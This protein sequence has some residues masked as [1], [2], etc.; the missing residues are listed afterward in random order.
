MGKSKVVYYGTT[1]I[2]LTS[3]TVEPSKLISGYTAHDK[4][5][6]PIVGVAAGESTMVV[7]A[8]ELADNY[9]SA[10]GFKLSYDNVNTGQTFV[11]NSVNTTQGIF[12]ETANESGASAWFLEAVSGYTN[13]YYIY[14]YDSGVKK[15]M[16][17]TTGNQMGL[18]QTNKSAFDVSYVSDTKFY[19]KLVGA[20]KWLQHSNGGGGIR[21]YTD[22]NNPNNTQLSLTYVENAIVPHGTLTI[23]SNGTYDV[24]NYAEVVVNV[25]G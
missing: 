1:L 16:Y 5:G 14:T 13:R 7:D 4:A 21:L 17:N 20:N 6:E 3:D 11:T 9:A 12:I 25:W 23:T 19:F 22:N 8:S 10:D 15:Y 24:T 18:H 2:D